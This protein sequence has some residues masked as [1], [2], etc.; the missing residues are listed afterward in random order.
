MQMWPCVATDTENIG[1][2][3]KTSIHVIKITERIILSLLTRILR[4][5]LEKTKQP[6]FSKLLS[7]APKKGSHSLQSLIS[8]KQSCPTCLIESSFILRC[9]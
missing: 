2:D 9:V 1:L 4:S 7:Q 6:C 8:G 3:Y 5:F